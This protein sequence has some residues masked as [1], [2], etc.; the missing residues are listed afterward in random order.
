[1]I[2]VR[3][4]THSRMA[5]DA[6]AALRALYAAAGGAAWA[7]RDNWLGTDTWGDTFAITQDPTYDYIG[8]FAD[9]TNGVRDLPFAAERINEGTVP[10]RAAICLGLCT[11]YAYFGL[12]WSNEC[13]CGN[14]YGSQGVGDQCGSAS[15][16]DNG[17]CSNGQGN[18][19][20]HNA[21]YCWG[22]C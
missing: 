10:E 4:D 8:C 19:G 13:F 18:C 12:Q 1:M 5:S 6:A 7:R 20:G 16:T 2:I 21:V 3:R 14:T 11:G 17:L 15:T 9:N 22:S